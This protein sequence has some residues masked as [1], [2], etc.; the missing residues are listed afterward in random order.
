[1]ITGMSHKPGKA[2]KKRKDRRRW[3]HMP[4]NA[5]RR[6]IKAKVWARDKGICQ[7][8]WLPIDPTAPPQSPEHRSLDHIVDFADGGKYT[9]DNLRLAHRLCNELR[10][11]E[12]PA[13]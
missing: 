2:C 10:G 3:A 8:C 9:V 12:N 13:V 5:R 7:L 11:R 1:M 4:T 6:V